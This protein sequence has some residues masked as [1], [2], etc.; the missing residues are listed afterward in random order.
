V[1]AAGIKDW[2]ELTCFPQFF[3]SSICF[4]QGNTE[5]CK[6]LVS[7]GGNI[8]NK[9]R[10]GT[11]VQCARNGGHDATADAMIQAAAEYKK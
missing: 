5:L 9:S 7:K 6:L 4:F 2:R 11:P 1:H 10:K 3:P 8:N